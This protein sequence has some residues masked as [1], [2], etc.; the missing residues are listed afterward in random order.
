MTKTI[1]P[2]RG[3]PSGAKTGYTEAGLSLAEN[4]QRALWG[5]L[6][7]G[8]PG[9]AWTLQIYQD[10]NPSQN[11]FRVRKTAERTGQPIDEIIAEQRN[12]ARKPGGSHEILWPMILE[13]IDKRDA[14][15][16]RDIANALEI[17]RPDGTVKAD[18]PREAALCN[19]VMDVL[20]KHPNHLFRIAELKDAPWSEWH[21]T[22]PARKTLAD[23]ARK[24]D[25]PMQLGRPK[26]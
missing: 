14:R 26:K 13:A 8:P 19:Y 20:S 18:D 10:R 17:L 16:F 7:S 2:K 12:L 15:F 24:L 1:K 3:R 25:I 6:H 5:H 21:T 11:S 9:S 22:E 4:E 23:Y